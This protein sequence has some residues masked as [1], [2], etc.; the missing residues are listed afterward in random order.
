MVFG[1]TMSPYYMNFIP[2]ITMYGLKAHRIPHEHVGYD[3]D[4]DSFWAII[5]QLSNE[6]YVIS[7]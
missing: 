1:A 6:I 2:N 5:I 7:E 3:R 4:I